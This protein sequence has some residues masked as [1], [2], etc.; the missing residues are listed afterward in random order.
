MVYSKIFIL[1][2]LIKSHNMLIYTSISHHALILIGNLNDVKILQ[3]SFGL[4]TRYG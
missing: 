4:K 3:S 2:H 1:I